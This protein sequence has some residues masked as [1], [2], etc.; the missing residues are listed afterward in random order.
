MQQRGRARLH[1]C[2]WQRSSKS[3]RRLCLKKF[4]KIKIYL[5]SAR[6]RAANKTDFGRI[7]NCT[8]A[9]SRMRVLQTKSSPH[10]SEKVQSATRLRNSW[11]TSRR[12]GRRCPRTIGLQTTRTQ[13]SSNCPTTPHTTRHNAS[14][15]GLRTLC[16]AFTSPSGP[17]A[18]KLSQNLNSM[19]DKMIPCAPQPKISLVIP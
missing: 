19:Q 18:P 9:L 13:T 8:L 12:H 11:W 17:N 6:A 14:R 10:K 4:R 16:C 2:W 7:T 3:S 5:G 15:A 1:V